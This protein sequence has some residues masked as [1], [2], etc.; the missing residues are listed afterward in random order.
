[1][2]SYSWRV[3]RAV[4]AL[5]GLVVT[6]AG[7]V[8]AAQA[9]RR[10]ASTD[11]QKI[12]HVVVIM[13]ENRSFDSYFGTYPAAEGI[14]GETWYGGGGGEPRARSRA[15]PTRRT[16]RRAATSRSTTP[17][18]STTAARTGCSTA[19]RISTAARWTVSSRR[20]RD[21]PSCTQP[22]QP[23]CSQGT[24][25]VMGY[26]D[27][28]DIPN[29]WAWAQNFVL[30]DRMFE[31]VELLVAAVA[32]LHGLELVGGVRPQ[33]GVVRRRAGVDRQERTSTPRTRAS[34]TTAGRTSPTSST[35]PTS[36]GA[37]TS[38]GV[39]TLTASRTSS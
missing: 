5:L 14:P 33:Q 32:S 3:L 28:G 38:S 17:A 19:S 10:N 21:S 24:L 13:Q 34:C 31:P 16:R 35:R 36:A 1:M 22:D 7:F 27:G 8:S 15:S 39:R 23:G 25:D 2:L 29:Y 37:T 6:A 20:S 12:Q 26:H 18:T 30:Q 9:R 11:V 4:L